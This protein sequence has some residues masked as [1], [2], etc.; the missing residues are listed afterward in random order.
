MART[1]TLTDL[2]VTSKDRNRLAL[3]LTDI[4]SGISLIEIIGQVVAFVFEEDD[5]EDDLE[6]DHDW[7]DCPEPGEPVPPELLDPQTLTHAVCALELDAHKCGKEDR[8]CAA[9]TIRQC[10]RVGDIHKVAQALV[11]IAE[12]WEGD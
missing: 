3:D 8:A 2:V 11:N 7:M 9:A 6:D 12:M 4:W 5:L 10:L 1:K